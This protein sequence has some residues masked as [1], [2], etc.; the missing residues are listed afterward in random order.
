ML[1]VSGQIPLDPGTSE[2]AGNNIRTQTRRVMRN[3]EAILIAAGYTLDDVVRTTVFLIN[4]SDFQEMN[5]V[6]A[7][8]MKSKPARSTIGV[9]DLP[10]GARIEID[11]IAVK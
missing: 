9:S 4:M 1:F 5:A 8:F 3:L 10:K 2:L 7:E 6:Y 11:A